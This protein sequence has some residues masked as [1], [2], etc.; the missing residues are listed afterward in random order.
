MKNLAIITTVFNHTNS[1]YFLNNWIIFI[2]YIKKLKL[3]NHLYVCEIL[4]SHHS[5][6]IDDDCNKFIIYNDSSLWHKECGL[7][8][9]LS[10]LPDN[11]TNVLAIDSD[12][13][14]S[15][16]NWYQKTLE[17]LK[18]SIMVQPFEKIIYFQ[19]DEASIDATNISMTKY[20]SFQNNIKQGNPGLAVAYNRNY[21]DSVGGFFD[22][23]L[24]GG[25]DV[26]NIIP[27]FYD[28]HEILYKILDFTFLDYKI[29]IINYIDNARKYIKNSKKKSFAYLEK[30]IAHHMFH[31]FFSFRQYHNRHQIINSIYS[32]VVEKNNYFY[33]IVDENFEKI[34]RSFL[35]KRSFTIKTNKPYIVST[36]KYGP[37]SD[38]VFWLNEESILYT[39]NIDKIKIKINNKNNLINLKICCNDKLLNID[40]LISEG[41]QIL[42]CE[43]P[44]NITIESNDSVVLENDERT[45][46]VFIEYIKIFDKNKNEYINFDLKDIL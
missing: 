43:N 33:K 16:D 24:I 40:E 3:I 32:N 12:I 20:C 37:D 39:F 2:D 31:G 26:V 35:Q 4:P 8:Y 41:S 28:T 10:K 1:P 30:N 5:S 25:G 29:K 9:L 13:V 23:C 14:F 34:Y 11:Y 22:G 46:S 36:C 42:D 44:K 6:L 19:N 38:N 15:D 27:F 45:L 7:N 21:L 18:E 17:A